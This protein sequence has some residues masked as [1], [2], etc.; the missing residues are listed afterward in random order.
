M[1]E[2][3]FQSDFQQ[4]RKLA[5]QWQNMTYRTV[6]MS[7]DKPRAAA[8]LQISPLGTGQVNGSELQYK[9]FVKMV[10]PL[11]SPLRTRMNASQDIT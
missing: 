4:A 6:Y 11:F 7:T 10:I 2:E 1:D 5:R 8:L 3:R 9:T